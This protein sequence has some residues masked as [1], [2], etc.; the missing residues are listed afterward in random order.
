MRLDPSELTLKVRFSSDLRVIVE[1]LVEHS[2][3]EVVAFNLGGRE[4][5]FQPVA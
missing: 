1:C 3:E 5:L 4:L 2:F